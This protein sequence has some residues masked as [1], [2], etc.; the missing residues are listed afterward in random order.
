MDSNKE[1][2]YYKKKFSVAE[3]DLAIDGYLSYVELVRQQIAFIKDF[4]IRKTLTVK[5]QKQSY[6]IG[7]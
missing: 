4:K 3:F 7:L 2:E 6:T 1:L 5:K